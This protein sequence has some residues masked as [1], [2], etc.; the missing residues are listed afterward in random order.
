MNHPQIKVHYIE[1][2]DHWYWCWN[3]PAAS[4]TDNGPFK[5]EALARKDAA[6]YEKA[7]EPNE[8]QVY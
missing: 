6:R 4:V 5:I 3:I 8:P 2:S 1:Y 7:W